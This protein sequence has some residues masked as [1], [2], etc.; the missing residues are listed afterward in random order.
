MLLTYFI[1]KSIKL[2]VILGPYLCIVYHEELKLI[3]YDFFY[4]SLNIILVT[5]LL[6]LFLSIAFYLPSRT[7]GVILL[8]LYKYT[9][10]FK[11][12]I[13]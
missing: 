1:S 2:T 12:R 3:K 6:S 13:N 7:C 4:T 9:D 5:F 10:Y 11:K 8:E